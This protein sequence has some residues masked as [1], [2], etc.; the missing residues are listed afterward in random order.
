MRS[1]L[2]SPLLF[3]V[4]GRPSRNQKEPDEIVL[5]L[6]GFSLIDPRVRVAR[7]ATS[8]GSLGGPPLPFQPLQVVEEKGRRDI[9]AIASLI[10]IADPQVGVLRLFGV[11]VVS[12]LD[13]NAVDRLRDCP[14]GTASRQRDKST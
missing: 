11:L 5:G 7:R 2:L 6:L 4:T 10:A 1:P 9:L 3:F 14:T 12:F 13:G 8:Y